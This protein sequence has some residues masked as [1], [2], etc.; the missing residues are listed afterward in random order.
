MRTFGTHHRE[1]THIHGDALV[2]RFLRGYLQI[3]A[4]RHG[5]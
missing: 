1:G 3:H 4:S 5:E 2:P